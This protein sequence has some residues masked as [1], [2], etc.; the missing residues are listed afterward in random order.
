M[1]IYRLLGEGRD[2]E[3]AQQSREQ[4]FCVFTVQ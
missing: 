1:M 4:E 2:S 3:L